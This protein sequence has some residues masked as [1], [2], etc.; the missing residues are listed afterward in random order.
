[1]SEMVWRGKLYQGYICHNATGF[2][3]TTDEVALK[4]NME[5]NSLF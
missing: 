3:W 1:M 5:T 2:S 4:G